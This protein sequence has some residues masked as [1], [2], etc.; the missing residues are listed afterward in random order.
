M[1]TLNADV[2]KSCESSIRGVPEYRMTPLGRCLLEGDCNIHITKSLLQNSADVFG[3]SSRNYE[4]PLGQD[5]P[6]NFQ[7]FKSVFEWVVYQMDEQRWYK[8]WQKSSRWSETIC[9]LL[10][11]VDFVVGFGAE[12]ALPPALVESGADQVDS[13][14]VVRFENAPFVSLRV[15]EPPSDCF[16]H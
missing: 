2:N 13:L 10:D 14:I 9:S 3:D 7:V 11:E 16:V 12:Q 15:V 5:H 4:I 6:R 1:I 8:R